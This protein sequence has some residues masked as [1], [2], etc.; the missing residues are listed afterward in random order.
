MI[1]SRSNSRTGKPYTVIW[2]RTWL[3]KQSCGLSVQDNGIGIA[4]ADQ[5][6][7]FGRFFGWTL[8]ARRVT[9]A[10]VW[11]Y[12]SPRVWWSSTT[13][14][15]RW[16]VRLEGAPASR[17]R[18]RAPRFPGLRKSPRPYPNGPDLHEK[19]VNAEAREDDVIFN[20][21]IIVSPTLLN[22][23]QL[24]FEKDYDP[25]RSV[26]ATQKIVVDG[27]FTGGGAQA[28]MLETEN[29]LKINDIVSWSHGHHYIKFGINIPNLSR[30]AW[31][32]RSDRLGT[33][34]FSSLAE[35]AANT[36]LVYAADWPGPHG[37]LDE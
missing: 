8:W 3:S 14:P 17:W 11:G 18:F 13:E 19:G 7:I 10:P 2:I 37:V 9:E 34:S 16:R 36:P 27:D 33:Y 31:D 23:L 15:Y 24:F 12:R 20:D 35:Y 5:D 28:D 25:T 6:R 4:R 1:D 26:L 30:R 29:N 22:Q 21:R 32:D